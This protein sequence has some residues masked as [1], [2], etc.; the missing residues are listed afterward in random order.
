MKIYF[1]N[2]Y[3]V[4][5]IDEKKGKVCASFISEIVTDYDANHATGGFDE[6]RGFLLRLDR[7]YLG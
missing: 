2:S 3:F 7:G 6:R 5:V 1:Q 4:K